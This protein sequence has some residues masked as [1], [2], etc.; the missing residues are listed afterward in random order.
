MKTKMMLK[1]GLV[2]AIGILSLMAFTGVAYADTNATNPLILEV[3]AGQG[4]ESHRKISWVTNWPTT[5]MVEYW[6]G[7]LPPSDPDTVPPTDILNWNELTNFHV[8]K[9]ER[10]NIADGATFHFRIIAQN[11]EV[12]NETISDVYTVTPAGSWYPRLSSSDGA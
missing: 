3:H 2:S 1:A 12:N 6:E 11:A 5:G 9:I 8:V 4:E 10:E 7:D